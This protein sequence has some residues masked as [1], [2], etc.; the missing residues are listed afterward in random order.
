ML[1]YSTHES[2]GKVTGGGSA[3]SYG[4]CFTRKEKGG[5]KRME[6]VVLSFMLQPEGDHYVSKFPGTGDSQFRAQ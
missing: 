4:F 3:L 5:E 2:L 6:Y 1:Q